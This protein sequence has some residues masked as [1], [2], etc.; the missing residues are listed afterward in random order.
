MKYNYR[1][2][3]YLLPPISS[4]VFGDYKKLEIIKV[5]RAPKV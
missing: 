1:V 4:P 5:E 3:E 2:L